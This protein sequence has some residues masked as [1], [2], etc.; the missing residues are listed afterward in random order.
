VG[1]L[2]A[3]VG[4]FVAAII[5]SSV[6][7]QLPIAG[8][9]PDLVFSV[10]IAVSMML[11]FEQGMAV[12]VAGGLTLDLLLPDRPVGATTLTLLVVCGLAM[13]V[14][15]ITGPRVLVVAI[16]V[17][18]F[19]F[20]YQAMILT[21]LALTRGIGI[22]TVNIPSLVL[23]GVVNAAIGIVAAWTLRALELRFGG[24]ERAQW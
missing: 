1:I 12:A 15:R 13:L 23:I 18:G 22:A 3:A 19:S 2:I 11:G 20:V 17:F 24:A 14:S 10:A 6:L 7:T 21:M 5:E 16:T 4:A 9:K 8:V